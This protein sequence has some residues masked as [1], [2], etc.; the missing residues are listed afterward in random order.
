MAW[1][2]TTRGEEMAIATATMA[3][4]IDPWIDLGHGDG[5]RIQQVSQSASRTLADRQQPALATLEDRDHRWPEHCSHNVSSVHYR[6][7]QSKQ[8]LNGDK[9]W[10][11]DGSR[12][13]N[14]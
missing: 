3:N 11:W 4:D 9:L 14:H 5:D 1:P 10:Q 7:I 6:S 8:Y 2:L 12:W 13:S